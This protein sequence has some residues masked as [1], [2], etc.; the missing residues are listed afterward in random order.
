MLAIIS[1]K[2]SLPGSLAVLLSTNHGRYSGFPFS[3]ILATQ[4]FALQYSKPA[5]WVRPWICGHREKSFWFVNLCCPYCFEI[6]FWA[7]K[8][9][10]AQHFVRPLADERK[11]IGL[12]NFILPELRSANFRIADRTLFCDFKN[13]F[14]IAEKYYK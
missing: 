10:Y 5:F 4:T 1:L 6:S 2:I 3:Q 7:I 12:Q 9:K 14:K 8:E 13:A 11:K